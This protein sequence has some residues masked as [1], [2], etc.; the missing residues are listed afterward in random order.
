[1]DEYKQG[2]IDT[3]KLVEAAA[4][5]LSMRKHSAVDGEMDDNSMIDCYRTL[6]TKDNTK[7]PNQRVWYTKN[8]RVS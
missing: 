7:Q 2:Q 6:C 5:D 3:D 8:P 4:L 1:M